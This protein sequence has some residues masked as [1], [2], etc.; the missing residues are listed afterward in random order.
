MKDLNKHVTPL[1]IKKWYN[2]GLE[3]LD[4]KHEYLLE[5]IEGGNQHD[6]QYCC[7]RMFSEWL[8]TTDT[9]TWVQL[10]VAMRNISLNEAASK[11][12]SLFPQGRVIMLFL[13]IAY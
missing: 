1:V 10:T 4:T 9:P 12:E 5:T 8:Q 3:L 13:H 6:M 2:L 11:I 7:R